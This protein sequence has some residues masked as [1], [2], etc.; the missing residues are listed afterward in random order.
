MRPSLAGVLWMCLALGPAAGF[1]QTV[2]NASRAAA[3]VG[4]A[5]TAR[6][7]GRVEEAAAYFRDGDRLQPFNG[8]LLVEY[9]LGRAGRADAASR[10]DR[11]ARAGRQP[12]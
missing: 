1:A 11:R 3:L 2:G 4:L 12:A 5:R 8:P 10:V 6:D 9:L 7:Q